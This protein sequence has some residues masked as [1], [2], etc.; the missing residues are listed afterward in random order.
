MNHKVKKHNKIGKRGWFGVFI[1][2]AGVFSMAGLGTV[3]HNRRTE[4]WLNAND[5]NGQ[6]RTTIDEVS[7]ELQGY[8]SLKDKQQQQ[9]STCLVAGVALVIW[10]YRKYNP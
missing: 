4:Q 10:G 8:K 9:G 3:A 7:A 1:I 6:L 2:V 5:G